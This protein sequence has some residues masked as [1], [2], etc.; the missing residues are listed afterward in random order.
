MTPLQGFGKTS[1]YVA[2]VEHRESHPLNSCGG[3]NE[4]PRRTDWTLKVKTLWYTEEAFT[5]RKEAEA[6]VASAMASASLNKCNWS[7][8]FFSLDGKRQTFRTSIWLNARICCTPRQQHIRRDAIG[9]IMNIAHQIIIG[10]HPIL[11]GSF[12]EAM[13]FRISVCP[14]HRDN[15]F[16]SNSSIATPTRDTPSP[17]DRGWP[18][19]PRS[20]DIGSDLAT[21]S[22]HTVHPAGATACVSGC[23]G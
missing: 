16:T 6:I 20:F 10:V 13:D 2:S 18:P 3:E 14:Q 7:Y 21:A 23:Y 22:S 8:P 19:R 5:H 11:L 1:E 12:N 4:H 17:D 15:V 9:S